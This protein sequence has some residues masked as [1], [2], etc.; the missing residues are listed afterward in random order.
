M[1]GLTTRLHML[2]AL[3]F[4]CGTSNIAAFAASAPQQWHATR[5]LRMVVPFAPGGGADAMARLI[6]PKL[7]EVVGQPIVIDN[8][9]GASGNIG[10]ELVAKSPPDGYTIM[11]TTA[12]LTIAP[13]VFTTLPF[14][15]V[16]DFTAVSLLAKAPSILAI[17]PALPAKTVKELIALA[18]AS[19]GKLNYASDGGGPVELGMELFKVAANVDLK[20]VPYKSTGPAVIAVI[21]GESSAIMA[22]ALAVMPHS[23]SGR[24]RALAITSAQRV[25]VLPDL[26]TIAESGVPKFEVNLWYGI[27][28]PAR[29]PSTIVAALN[30]YFAAVIQSPDIKARLTNEASIPAVSTPQ[31]F[32]D[33]VKADIDKWA[34]A[35][36]KPAAAVK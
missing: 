8:R 1:S 33:F 35:A 12:N 25:D 23:K 28:A 10:A 14:D 16:R 24:L 9:A 29:V 15:V 26:P 11:M 18:K 31:E 27:L 13:S 34:L 2:A 21:S 22:P 7:V 32:A 3:C 20:N 17:H 4:V 19:P 36:R 6:Q 30:R 5:P